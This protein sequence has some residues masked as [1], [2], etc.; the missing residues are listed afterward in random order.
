M[1]THVIRKIVISVTMIATLSILA[2]VYVMNGAE[3]EDAWLYLSSAG[4]VLVVL[5]PELFKKDTDQ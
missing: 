5:I 2:T 1:R 4:V 3:I